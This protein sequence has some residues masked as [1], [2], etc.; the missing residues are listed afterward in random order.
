MS[1][2]GA[3]LVAA[4]AAALMVFTAAYD[5]SAQG[6]RRNCSFCPNEA[7]LSACVSCMQNNNCRATKPALF[8]KRNN[9]AFGAPGK[10]GNVYSSRPRR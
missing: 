7:S 5:A 8:C 4:F 3:I 1:K 6:S 10:R 2:F 9:P